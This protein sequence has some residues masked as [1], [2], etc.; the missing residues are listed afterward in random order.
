MCRNLIQV[1]EKTLPQLL[2]KMNTGRKCLIVNTA[3]TPP[4]ITNPLQTFGAKG[5]ALPESKFD[6]TRTLNNLIKLPENCGKI[7]C[8]IV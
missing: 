5:F 3:P 8:E 6:A 7:F 2:T 1:N 4:K